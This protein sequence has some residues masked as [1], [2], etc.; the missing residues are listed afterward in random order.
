MGNGKYIRLEI[1]PG[2]CGRPLE[3]GRKRERRNDSREGEPARGKYHRTS[4][5]NYQSN[6]KG[7]LAMGK[8]EGAETKALLRNH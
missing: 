4:N 6:L 1:L 5:K 3:T 2:A 8:G 7:G